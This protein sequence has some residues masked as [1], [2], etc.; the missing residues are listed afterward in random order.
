MPLEFRREN[1]Q[2]VW[3]RNPFTQTVTYFTDIHKKRLGFLARPPDWTMGERTRA[4]GEGE[5]W[6]EAE[7][8][9]RAC[10][11]CPGN[12][13]LTMAEVLRVRPAEVPGMDES[14]GEW[15]IRGFYNIVPRV[16]E[17]CTGGRDESYVV[18]EDPRGTSP[19][20]PGTTTTC[21]TARSSRPRSLPP[22][23]VPTSRSRG[24]PTPTRRCRRC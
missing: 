12:E 17:C 16:P 24:S 14:T 19:T 2:L 5:W 8:L 11:F 15:L 13:H 20:G 21:S 3:V 10:A 6:A 18:V 1:G 7:A 22:W 23:C 9:R 4:A